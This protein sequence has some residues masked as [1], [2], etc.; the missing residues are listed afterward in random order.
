MNTGELLLR[1][2]LTDPADDHARLVYA[3]YLD[4]VA[5]R[6]TERAEFIRV[7]VELAGLP[8]CDAEGGI[9]CSR[10]QL[11]T[12]YGRYAKRCRGA[13]CRLRMREYYTS[14]RYLVWDWCRSI[15]A[16]SWNKYHRGFVESVTCTVADFMRNARALF[17]QHPIIRVTLTDRQPDLF[18]LS[19]GAASRVWN[20]Q[21]TA[22]LTDADSLLPRELYDTLPEDNS[23]ADVF[24][25]VGPGEWFCRDTA[26][27]LDALSEA[28]V[29]YGRQE[30]GLPDLTRAQ[31]GT[32]PAPTPEGEG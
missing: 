28:C 17:L 19:D 18:D 16:G 20:R 25:P 8:T 32:A 22:P 10:C 21:D 13:V 26:H 12:G 7:Q 15:P 29:R 9:Y 6:H 27:A 30:A 3:D 14:R 24:G 23:V 11:P 4:E 2:I 1:A 31:V 5:G